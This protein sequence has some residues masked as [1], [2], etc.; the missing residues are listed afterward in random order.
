MT[1]GKK[2]FPLYIVNYLPHQKYF[3]YKLYILMISIFEE[4]YSLDCDAV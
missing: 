2:L 4:Y 1:Q 3:K